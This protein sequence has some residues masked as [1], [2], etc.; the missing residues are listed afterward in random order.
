MLKSHQISSVLLWKGKGLLLL[1]RWLPHVFSHRRSAMGYR[2]YL[3][4]LLRNASRAALRTCVSADLQ[5][6]ATPQTSSESMSVNT[7]SML[8]G[9]HPVSTNCHVQVHQHYGW[10]S[11]EA[12]TSAACVR[13]VSEAK[14]QSDEAHS[15]ALANARAAN[16][17]GWPSCW[18]RCQ[19]AN[20]SASF[21]DDRR[22]DVQKE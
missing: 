12:Q 19:S 6:P 15:M 11:A 7:K 22:R 14:G 20:R 18:S 8:G 13:D 5:N 9:P 1:S 2:H 17:T 10:P 21:S 3:F 4:W 16:I